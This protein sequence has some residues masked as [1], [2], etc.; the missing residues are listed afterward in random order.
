MRLAYCADLFVVHCARL[1]VSVFGERQRAGEEGTTAV[2]SSPAACRPSRAGP[3]LLRQL[4]AVTES[5]TVIVRGRSP[6]FQQLW[7]YFNT[8]DVVGGIV[9]THGPWLCKWAHTLWGPST[10]RP[11][12]AARRPP[13]SP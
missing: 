1:A 10:R 8:V 2:S 13:S 4:A 9:V 6:R 12:P 5:V 11:P 3:D 7:F